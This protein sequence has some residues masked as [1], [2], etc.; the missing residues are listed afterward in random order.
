[1]IP[2]I[3]TPGIIIPGVII[4]FGKNA[5]YSRMKHF[6]LLLLL[7]VSTGSFAQKAPV[8][9][10]FY[11]FTGTID[12]YP[13]T[14]LLHRTNYDFSGCYYYNSSVSPIELSGKMDKKGFLK[15]KHE[16]NDSK[17]NEHIE[18]VFKD[19]SFA[20]TWESKGKMLNVRVTESID[21]SLLRF[22]YIWTPGERKLVKKP[23]YLS[24]IDEIS[25]EGKSVW[26]AANS[27]HPATQLVREVIREMFGEKASNEA[28][29]PIM[30]RQKNAFL[31]VPDDSLEMYMES[32]ATEVAYV[33]ARIL[34]LSQSWYNFAGGAHGMHGTS[35]ENIDLKNT[36]RLT[37]SD[38][39]DTLTAKPAMEKILEKEFR[40]NFP[41]EEGEKLK[42][43]LL[44]EKIE[45]T[46]N[47]ML[48]A[49]G[50]GFQYDP[51]EIAA[52]AYGPIFIYITFKEIQSY[53][54]PEFKKLVGL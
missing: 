36:R 31:S 5:L 33:D 46:E 35:Y 53:L 45:P 15:L 11:Y 17:N 52:Y 49:K 2:G 12:K 23:E 26:P 44:V 41:F 38:I 54:K 8:V 43:V 20:G 22:D 13:V 51:Y 39:I 25:W 16:G 48:T 29:G 7:A 37:L 1:M 40:K 32:A 34:S 19:T 47:F 6:I 42:D 9:T 24:H 50:I 30:I 27:T 14:F 28:I 3:K 21:P 4:P 18:G 10:S